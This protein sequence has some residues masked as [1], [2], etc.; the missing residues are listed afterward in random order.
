[1]GILDLF[2]APKGDTTDIVDEAISIDL[3]LTA[4]RDLNHLQREL[5]LNERQ[6]N[7]IFWRYES[8]KSYLKDTNRASIGISY[9]TTAHYCSEEDNVTV[10][11]RVCDCLV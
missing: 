9:N 4:A 7:R 10:K 5:D 3:L 1:M 6:L 11:G 8:L 2:I